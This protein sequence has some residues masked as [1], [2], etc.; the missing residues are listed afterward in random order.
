ME[1]TEQEKFLND[2]GVNTVVDVFEQPLEPEKAETHEE[3]GEKDENTE[4]G[5]KARN[6]REKRL[7][8]QLQ[9]EREEKIA[10]SARLEA[11][12]ES[13]RMREGSEASEYQKK[14]EK[15]YGTDSPEARE[16]TELLAT[17]LKGVEER[18]TERA[19]EKFRE[20]QRIESEAVRKEESALD[21]MIETIEDEFELS[22][23]EQQKKGFFTLL[24]KMSPKNDD[25]NII[26]YA[27]PLSVWEVYSEKLKKKTDSRAKDLSSRSMVHSGASPESKLVDETMVR[28]LKEQGIL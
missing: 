19:L 21:Q 25:G 3:E 23:S 28:F 16:A 17:A 22:L 9:A 12:E 2:L 15:I 24:E 4:Q 26:A 6:R 20:E 8:S 13:R 11:I 18:A 5:I 1:K 10:L 7:V 14:V 27:D